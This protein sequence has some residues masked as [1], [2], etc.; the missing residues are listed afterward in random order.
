MGKPVT[1]DNSRIVT[2]LSQLKDRKVLRVAV[3]YVVVAW[4]VMQ[5]GEVT[6]EA[7][8][9]PSW[10]LTML[11][12]FTLLGFPFALVLAWAYEITPGGIV[13]DHDGNLDSAYIPETH[14]RLETAARS[15]EMEPSIAVLLFEDM[16]LNKD[17]EYFC[18]GI[19]EEI[20]CALSE[21]DGL[22]VAAMVIS[23]GQGNIITT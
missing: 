13:R 8:K 5:V 22:H 7:L 11:I 21:V 10:A 1:V 16:S 9:L 19:A 18:E 3:A 12:T 17:Q 14:A 4:I 20:L 15:E 6:F 2:L 23:F